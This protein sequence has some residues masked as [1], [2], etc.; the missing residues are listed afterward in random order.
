[1]TLLLQHPDTDRLAPATPA[2]LGGPAAIVTPAPYGEA[3]VD[4]D[5]IRHNVE[6]LSR[7]ARGGLMAVVKADGFGHGAVQVARTALASGATWLGVT[8][9]AEAHELRDADIEAPLLAWMYLPDD[10]LWPALQRD[11]DLSVSTFEQLQAVTRAASVAGRPARIHLK[12]DTGMHRAGAD[13]EGWPALVRRARRL[14]REGLVDVRGIWS[15]LA[16]ADEPE[17]EL[18]A[19]QQ[20]AFEAALAIARDGGLD[21]EVV[22]LANSAGLLAHPET[23]YDLVRVGIALYGVEPIPGRAHGLRPAM[24][25]RGRVL[26]HRRAT[27]GQGVSYG[28]DYVTDRDTTLALVPLGFADGLPRAASGRAHVQL[29]GHRHPVAG[30]IAMDQIVVDAGNDAVSTGDHVVLFGA[31]ERGEPTVADWAAWAGT[32]P[33]EIL[34]G[35]GTRV[36]RSYLDVGSRKQQTAALDSTRY[37]VV[38]FFVGRD[39]RWALPVATAAAGPSAAQPSPAGRFVDAAEIA[40]HLRGVDIVF[41]A[42][43]GPFGEDGT[44]QGM[45][46]SIGVPFVGS[47]VLASAVGMDKAVA[48][49]LFRAHGHSVADGVV[50]DLGRDDLFADERDR[51]GLPVVVKPARAGSS[52]GVVRVDDWADLAA[53]I[54]TARALDPKVIVERFVAGREVDVAVLQRPDGVLVAGPPLEIGYAAGRGLFDYEAKYADTEQTHFQIPADLPAETIDRLCSAAL[55]VFRL[56]GCAGLLR[57]DFLLPDD[58]APVV[59]EVNTMPGFTAMSQFPQI[60]Q[61]AGLA[62]SDLLDVLVESALGD[63]A[64][65]AARPSGR[66]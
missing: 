43:H 66:S 44:L 25:L 64:G 41:P 12:V 47:G 2:T 23:H 32:N 56:L 36:A 48:K 24:T 8:S 16:R 53:A 42:L 63:R 65:A 7:M 17:C 18:T 21:P 29:A 52:Q 34:V 13:P 60:W 9:L 55:D 58:G 33:H 59:N 30:R 31:A 45:L 50:L 20:R 26:Q 14:E 28:H 39:G 4:L 40:R 6:L 61:A 10:D 15:H 35:I 37:D 38:P 46:A 22:H 49:Q 5:A 11:I 54:D 62:Y 1:M 57:V 51:L 3:V 27:A 19:L